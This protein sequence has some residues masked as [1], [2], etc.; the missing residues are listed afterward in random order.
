MNK[1]K[2]LGFSALAGS[3]ALTSA[4]A[5]EV[6]VA[7]G[8]S[9]TVQHIGNNAANSGKTFKMGNQLTFTGAGELDNGMNVKIVIPLILGNVLIIFG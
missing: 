7:G 1:L 3:L 8:A 6:T 5:G 9:M 2:T 4:Y